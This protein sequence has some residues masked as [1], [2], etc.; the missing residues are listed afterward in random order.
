[1]YNEQPLLEFRDVSFRYNNGEDVL[2][3]LS[4]AVR[5]KESVVILGQSGYGKST[6]LKLGSR[7]LEASDGTILYKG[8]NIHAISP[9]VLRKEIAYLSQTPCLLEGS[10]ESNLLLP[11]RKNEFPHDLRERISNILMLVGL[12][13]SFLLRRSHELSVGEKQRIA[14][15]RTLINRPSVLLLDEPNTALDEENIRILIHSLKHIIQ[16]DAISMLVVTHQLDFAKKLGNR[17]L[18][19][20]KGRVKEIECPESAFAKDGL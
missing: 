19:L 4:L 2:H 12:N 17:F 6:L 15:A 18:V 8:I 20:K 3:K 1:M 11:F 7:L 14:L 16:R 5:E 13:E 10:V 9:L